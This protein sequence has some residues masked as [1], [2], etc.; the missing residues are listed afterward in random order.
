MVKVRTLLFSKTSKDSTTL[1]IGNVISVGLNLLITLIL[2]RNL[3]VA[4]MGLFFTALTVIQLVADVADLGINSA[5]LNFLPGKS[6]Q[7]IEQ[8]INASWQVK[9]IVS[10]AIGLGLIT[11]ASPI[12]KMIFQ[13]N[14][15]IYLLQASPVGVFALLFIFWGQTVF[16]ARGKFLAAAIIN[17]AINVSRVLVVILLIAS[18]GLSLLNVFLSFQIV[19]LAIVFYLFLILRPRITDLKESMVL[20]KFGLPVGLSFALAAVYTKLDQILV[21]RIA[22]EGEA[23]IFGLASRLAAFYIFATAAL[24][25]ALI[26]RFASLPKDFFSGYFKK[27]FLASFLLSSIIIA[28]MI[29]VSLTLPIMFGEDFRMSVAIFQILSLGIVFFTMSVPLSNAILYHYKKTYFSLITS[30]ILALVLFGAL[31]ILIP[32]YGGVGA[33]YAVLLGYMVQFVVSLVYFIF[34]KQKI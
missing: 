14:E 29:P 32:I 15:M 18:N 6:P 28:T 5:I 11:L 27:S 9:L 16:Q 21:L 17:T 20:L 10:L 1:L 34:L 26:P 12:S 25:S 31:N 13:N 24:S 33:S 23:G 22:G 8:L 19:L 7:R 3:S 30:V 4:E 2:A